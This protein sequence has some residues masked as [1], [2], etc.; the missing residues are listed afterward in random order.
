MIAT[1]ILKKEHQIILSK[2]TEALE[3]CEK[4]TVID[5]PFWEI[6]VGFL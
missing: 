5:I 3:R 1:E 2:I 4:D 6:F